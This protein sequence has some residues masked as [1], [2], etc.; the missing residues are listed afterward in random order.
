MRVSHTLQSVGGQWRAAMEVC[1]EHVNS[2]EKVGKELLRGATVLEYVVK[3]SKR[4]GLEVFKEE[5]SSQ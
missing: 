2:M 5:V 3:F 1:C 4:I